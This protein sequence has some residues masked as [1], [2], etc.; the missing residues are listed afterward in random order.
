MTTLREA[1]QQALE[2]LESLFNW[3]VDTERGQRCSDAITALKAAL[4]EPDTC[5]W[6]QDGDSDSSM[7][8]T[9]CRQYFDVTDGTPEDNKMRWCCY[10]GKR[11][12]QLLTEDGDD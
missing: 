5:T 11:L 6:C 8:Q 3:Q 12:V 2:A 9:S 4:A 1:A 7:Y 10:C